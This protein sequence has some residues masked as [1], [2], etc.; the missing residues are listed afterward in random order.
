MFRLDQAKIESRRIDSAKITCEGHFKRAHWD[1][2][3]SAVTW[4]YIL[5]TLSVMDKSCHEE[6]QCGRNKM[7]HP[8]HS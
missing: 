1:V 7:I 5:D 6:E 2:C 3:P 4:S 8:C